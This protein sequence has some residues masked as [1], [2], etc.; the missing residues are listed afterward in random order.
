MGTM[1][2][3]ARGAAGPVAVVA[4][5]SAAVVTGAGRAVPAHRACGSPLK[6]GV[7]TLFGKNVVVV[8]A[9]RFGYMLSYC[10]EQLHAT[11][12]SHGG[13]RA[14]INDIVPFGWDT[15]VPNFKDTPEVSWCEGMS[16][17]TREVH[18]CHRETYPGEGKPEYQV[19]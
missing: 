18:W 14:A 8:W 13:C 19:M 3:D 16:S 6:D 15:A 17:D 1:V 4:R 9:E 12:H 5:A 7:I 2:I 11:H 10:A